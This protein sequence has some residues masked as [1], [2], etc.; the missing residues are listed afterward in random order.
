MKSMWILGTLPHRAIRPLT[1]AVLKI[2][3]VAGRF[4]ASNILQL[5]FLKGLKID[6][7][8]KMGLKTDE[9]IIGRIQVLSMAKMELGCPFL[10]ERTRHDKLASAEKENRI[11]FHDPPGE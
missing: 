7:L 8:P 6:F 4:F 11:I 10:T 1:G 5:S 3:I 2:K 9:N